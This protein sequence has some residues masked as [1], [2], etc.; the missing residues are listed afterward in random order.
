MPV[1]LPLT[2]HGAQALYAHFFLSPLHTPELRAHIRYAASISCSAQSS[3]GGG[4]FFMVLA[5]QLRLLSAHSSL[6][7]YPPL[8]AG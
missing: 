5:A 1:G 6:S 8:S 2:K 7:V 4:A 3:W